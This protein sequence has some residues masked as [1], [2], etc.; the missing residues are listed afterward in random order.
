MIASKI[1]QLTRHLQEQS[2]QYMVEQTSC[3]STFVK[4]QIVC[5]DL[6]DY[7]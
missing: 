6:A 4:S 3:V 7:D 1:V 2:N 5:Q